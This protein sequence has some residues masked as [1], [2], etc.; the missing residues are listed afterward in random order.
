MTAKFKESPKFG[1]GSSVRVGDQKRDNKFKIPGPG[2]YSVAD[3][4]AWSPKFAFG[5]QAR[6][7]KAKVPCAPPPG[8]YEVRG[9]LEACPLAKSIAGRRE[10]ARSVSGPGPGHYA[11]KHAQ[12]EKEGEKYGFSQESREMKMPK[13][14]PGP[15]NYEMLPDLGGNS[16]NKVSLSYSFTSR[17]KPLKS[18]ATP[19][20]GVVGEYSQ[21]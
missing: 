1:F 13:R 10:G 17:R 3:P 2:E 4:N 18:D 11:P 21:F 6:L 16:V 12:T 15:G 7:P 8:L 5:S 19:G 20:P 14:S 9:N